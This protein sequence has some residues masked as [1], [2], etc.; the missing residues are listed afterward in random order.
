MQCSTLGKLQALQLSSANSLNRADRMAKIFTISGRAIRIPILSR[1][2]ILQLIGGT[3]NVQS[4]VLQ[5]RHQRTTSHN[6]SGRVLRRLVVLGVL[7]SATT[8]IRATCSTANSVQRETSLGNFRPTLPL[9]RVV[10][11]SSTEVGIC[12]FQRSMSSIL[13]ISPYI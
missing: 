9:E 8:Q 13:C 1:G 5:I 12:C 10:T 6:L 11:A 2:P 7:L 3:P 4:T